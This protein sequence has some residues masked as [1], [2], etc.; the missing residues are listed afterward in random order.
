MKDQLE[1]S[2]YVENAKGLEREFNA[3]AGK[4]VEAVYKERQGVTVS[5]TDGSI[6]SFEAMGR[7]LTGVKLEK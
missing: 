6:M 5:F 3:L 4:T 1:F 7:W 2:S